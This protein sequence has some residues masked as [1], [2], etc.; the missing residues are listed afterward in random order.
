MKALL[1]LF[2]LTSC[3]ILRSQV[4]T[5]VLNDGSEV[6]FLEF[7]IPTKTEKTLNS[8]AL[9]LTGTT[10]LKDIA[11]VKITHLRRAG[12]RHFASINS[13][14]KT[15]SLTGPLELPKGKHKFKLTLRTKPNGSNR[16]R[17]PRGIGIRR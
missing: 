14:S 12:D 9:N 11:E 8:I 7:T 1:A 3:S 13:P 6:T 16:S 4:T 2:L 17:Q 15:H 10:D 5:P